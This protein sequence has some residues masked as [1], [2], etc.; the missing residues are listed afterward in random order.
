MTTQPLPRQGNPRQFRSAGVTVTGT[1]QFIAPAERRTRR[2][3]PATRVAADGSISLNLVEASIPDAAR[4][5]LGDALRLNYVVEAG[6]AG[7]ITLQTS[8]PLTRPA[9]LEAFQ[10]ALEFNGATLSE[11][12]DL[13]TVLPIDRAAPRFVTL[14]DIRGLGRRIVVVPLKFVSTEEMLRLLEPITGQG[15]VLRVSKARNLLM[16]SGGQSEIDAVLEAVNLFDV[17]VLRGKSFALVQLRAATPE[18]IAEELRIVFDTLEGGALE[19][20]VDFVPNDR[21]GSI[22]VIS[23]RARYISEAKAWIQ[24]LDAS[25]GRSQRFP[26][27][28]DLQNR[29]AGD[30]APILS[31]LIATQ[32]TV[33]VTDEAATVAA[34][35]DG[36]ATIVP[37]DINN[38]IIVSGTQP[39]QDRIGRL[40][41]RLDATP[42]QVLLEATIAEVMLNDE[43]DFG[44]RWFFETG[45]FSVSFSDVAAGAVSPVFPGFSFL[46]DGGSARVALS[47]LSAITDVK[48]VSSPSLLVLDNREA[49][50]RV[51]DQVPVATQSVVDAANPDAPIVN[52]IS[53][54]DTG[55][56]L[57]VRPRVSETGR[58]IMDIEQEVSDVVETTTSGID[59]PTISQRLVRTS[60]VVDDGQTLALGGLIQDTDSVLKTQVPLLGDIPILGEAFKSKETLV[61]RSELLILITPRVIRSAEEGQRITREFRN[62]LSAPDQLLSGDPQPQRHQIQRLFD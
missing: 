28:Y 27:V 48:I 38:A 5:V 37:D 13:V 14:G 62:R 61:D 56:I 46:F 35:P 25:A 15:T 23:S 7:T 17:N 54:R 3:G 22:L 31:S 57:R 32:E 21:L 24:Q 45:N 47:A 42:T 51:G 49:E 44:V 50:L 55:I 30:L 26:Q 8:T 52:S 16:I 58:V 43:L 41:Q 6:V 11:T 1:D 2:I 60:V 12:G 40:I 36:E 20:I 18:D 29:T 34:R 4:A 33:E 10:T 59:S 53:F 39:E 19:G 9:L